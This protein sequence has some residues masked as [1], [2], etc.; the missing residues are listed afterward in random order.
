MH[1]KFQSENL[2][3]LV[4]LEDRG[5]DGSITCIKKTVSDDIDSSSGSG[6]GSAMGSCE[7]NNE[8]S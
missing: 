6:Q 7:H 2:K 3:E 1:S 4:Y 5:M 8:L